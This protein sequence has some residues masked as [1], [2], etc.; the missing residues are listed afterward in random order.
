MYI[1]DKLYLGW[2]IW[3]VKGKH[4]T[5]CIR[6]KD[7]MYYERH[8]GDWRAITADPSYYATLPMY[9]LGDYKSAC[10][11]KVGAKYLLMLKHLAG[12]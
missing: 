1:G 2:T 11:R 3:K 8:P 5:F 12:S 10:F 6:H 7:T 9:R 4:D